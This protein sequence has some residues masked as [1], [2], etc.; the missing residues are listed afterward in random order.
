MLP[1]LLLDVPT[2][3]VGAE[4]THAPMVDATVVGVPTKLIVDTGSSD[5][6][7]EFRCLELAVGF[8]VSVPATRGRSR[9]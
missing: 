1:Q 6:T 5:R 4:L 3:D 2:F 8:R 9:D 7:A